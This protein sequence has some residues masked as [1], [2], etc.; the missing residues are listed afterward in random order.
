MLVIVSRRCAS[1]GGRCNYVWQALEVSALALQIPR[2]ESG[3]EMQ[4]CDDCVRE[5]QRK[6][7]RKM[8][9]NPGW[10]WCEGK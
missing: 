5:M 8:L 9:R 7:Q 10:G 1:G 4:N 2:G 6:K 3:T